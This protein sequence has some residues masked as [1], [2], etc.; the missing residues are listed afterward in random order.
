MGYKYEALPAHAIYKKLT[1]ANSIILAANT[2]INIGIVDGIFEAAKKMN[3]IVIFELAKSESD[4]E[5]G[6]TGLTPKDFAHNVKVAA[7]KANWP[8][9]IIHGD[10][11]TTKNPEKDVPYVKKLVKQQIESGFSSFAIDASFLFNESGKTTIEELAR[12]VEVTT[13]IANFIKNNTDKSNPPGL[14]VEVGE[15]GKRDKESGLVVT[16]VDEATTFIDQ[17]N[18]NEVYPNLL[19][20]ANGSTHGN[21]YDD[22]GK[23]IEQI[24]IDIPRTIEIGKALEKFDV[25]IAQHGITGTPL[26]LIATKFPKDV[27]QK[28]NVGTYWMNIAWDVL[29]VFE[30]QLFKTITEWTLSEAKERGETKPDAIIFGK[31]S[32]YAI[33]QYFDKIYAIDEDTQEALKAIAYSEALKFFRAFNSKNLVKFLK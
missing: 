1:K 12:N 8:W 22:S 9:F 21:I 23:L 3:T 14:E 18:K 17:L 10:H 29:K 7:E 13:E 28:G 30:P 24:T 16:T 6:Y 2:R 20:I 33:K 26:E 31:N 32:K 4:L 15:I 5:G 27:I 25:K 11:L 19:A